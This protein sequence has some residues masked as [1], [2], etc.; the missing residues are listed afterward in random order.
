MFAHKSVPHL[1]SQ[2]AL[3]CMA[4]TLSFDTVCLFCLRIGSSHQVQ[5]MSLL[6]SYGCKLLDRVYFISRLW[7]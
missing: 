6:V 2:H 7:H 3:A 1:L 5:Y 4:K